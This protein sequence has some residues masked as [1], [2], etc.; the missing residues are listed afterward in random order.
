MNDSIDLEDQ[1][2]DNENYDD[3]VPDDIGKKLELNEKN[4]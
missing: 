3:C 2:N 4:F 1:S